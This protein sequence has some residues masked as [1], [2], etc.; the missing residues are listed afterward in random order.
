MGRLGAHQLLA[1]WTFKPQGCLEGL[2]GTFQVCKI[3]GSLQNLHL[4]YLQVK[5][6]SLTVL[7]FLVTKPLTSRARLPLS[8]GTS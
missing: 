1:D 6:V 5:L 4:C 2:K 7:F 3:L 8:V